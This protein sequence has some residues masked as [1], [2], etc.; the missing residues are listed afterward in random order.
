[1]KEKR[2]CFETPVPNYDM[3]RIEGVVYQDEIK[4][5]DI[6]E[7]TFNGVNILSV[8]NW[9]GDG[10][11]NEIDKIY[12]ATASHLRNAQEL[13]FVATFSELEA[14]DFAGR[15]SREQAVELQGLYVLFLLSG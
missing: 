5:F 12:N 11:V 9:L 7:V 10:S 3:L 8:L 1:M 6:D 15:L 4:G 14:R 2:F 13:V